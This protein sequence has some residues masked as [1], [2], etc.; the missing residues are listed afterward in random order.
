MRVVLGVASLLV[1]LAV[2]AIVAM[3]QLKAVNASVSAAPA[4]A[5]LPPQAASEGNVREQSQQLQQRVRDDVTKAL[6]QG[7]ARSDEPAQ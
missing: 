5:E 1:A 7:A 3:K 6:Q 2:V 4:E